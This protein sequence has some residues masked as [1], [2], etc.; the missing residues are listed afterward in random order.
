MKSIR[1]KIVVLSAAA[2]LIVAI[3]LS[4][5]FMVILKSSIDEQVLALETT[6]RDNFDLLIKSEIE[7]AVSMLERIAKLRDSGALSDTE[8]RSFAATVLRDIR[9]GNDSYFWAD[10][11]KGDNVVLLGG[12]RR[13]PTGSVSK[14]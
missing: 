4:A 12:P 11:P 3:S 6:M 7:T 10:T 14:T 9:Y 8:A 1:T 5:V 13:G 2:A